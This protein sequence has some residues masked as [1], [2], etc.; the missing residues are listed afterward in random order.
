MN[1]LTFT[2]FRVFE[3]VVPARA[4]ILLAPSKGA[5]YKG[6]TTWPDMPIHLV[7]GVTS[8]GFRAVGECGRGTSRAVVENTLR[9]LL[10]RNLLEKT[11]PTMWMNSGDLPQSYPFFSWTLAGDR[12]Y[13]LM[14]S[15]WLDA[16]GKAAGL[17]AHQLLG[18]AIRNEVLTAFWANRPPAETMRALIH[19]A[20]NKG[21]TG[22]KMKSDSTCDTAR[23]LIEIA[24][25]VP[26]D[27]RVTID[28]MSSWRS[29]RESVRWI[30]KLATLPF[31][32]ILEDPFPTLAVEDWREVR[33][34]NPLTIVLYARD[35]SDL[36]RGL[37]DEMADA[38][39]LAGGGAHDFLRTVV[40]AE[41]F[42]KDCWHGSALELGVY[43]HVRLHAAAC[44][45]NCV[46]ASDLQS[47]W[48]REHTLVTPRMAYNGSYAILPDRPGLGVELD[49][50]AMQ[51]YL[52]SEFE[53]A[54]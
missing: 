24:A 13:H 39:N 6:T 42:A 26:A 11:P 4:D 23:A 45:R 52:R 36:R 30:E 9:D 35:E 10:R 19:E 54:G 46:L 17:P 18:G 53:V 28:P 38:Y 47:E 32:I 3:V 21:L 43:Q 31:P 50:A 48:V 51:K 20:A 12:S 49:H 41:S 7:E 1:Q 14:E 37:R 25:D 33:T 44:A 16:V 15:L 2:Q 5:I 40:V 22:I 29:L 34:Y 27:F 8:Q